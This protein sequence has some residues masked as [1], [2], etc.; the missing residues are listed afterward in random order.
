MLPPMNMYGPTKWTESCNNPY[1]HLLPKMIF[2]NFSS[3][4]V[5]E[6][7]Y[8]CWKKKISSQ[9]LGLM[10]LIINPSLHTN[11]YFLYQKYH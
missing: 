9:N 7:E 6:K 3:K 2:K 4:E 1:N 8:G 10:D 11:L 5:I